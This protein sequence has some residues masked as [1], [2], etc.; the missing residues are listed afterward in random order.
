MIFEY[1]GNYKQEANKAVNSN[2]DAIVSWYQFQSI[3]RTKMP[4]QEV[5]YL[6]F[7]RQ[8]STSVPMGP[9]LTM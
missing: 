2:A 9:I 8:C 3:S 7:W 4:I 5:I 1:S 6:K